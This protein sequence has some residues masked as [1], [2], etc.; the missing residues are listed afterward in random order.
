MLIIDHNE[1]RMYEVQVAQSLFSCHQINVSNLVSGDVMCRLVNGLPI[2]LIS[3]SVFS[4]VVMSIDRNRALLHISS[5]QLTMS[6]AKKGIIFIWI[7][8]TLVAVPTFIEYS[9]R[10]I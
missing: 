9:V 5:R 7:A 10:I 2:L 1:V 3:V 4:L 8:A 6:D